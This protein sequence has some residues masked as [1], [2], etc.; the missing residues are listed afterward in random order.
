MGRAFSFGVGHVGGLPQGLKPTVTV[1][2]S[3]T[4]EAVP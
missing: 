4:A 1:A 3:G 2:S